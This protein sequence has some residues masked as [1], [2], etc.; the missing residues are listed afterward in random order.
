MTR[1][2][3]TRSTAAYSVIVKPVS[4]R[5]NLA[6][7]YCYYRRVAGMYPDAPAAAM[8]DEVLEALTVQVLRDS[9]PQAVF[10]WQGG[11]PLLAGR[12]FYD[13][14]FRLQRRYA[15]PGQIVRN[16]IQT[17][18]TLIDE[19]WCR[20]FR[21]RQVLVGLS[22]DGPAE[23]HD[24]N[25]RGVGGQPTHAAVMRGMGLL[26]KHEVAFNALSVVS[27]ATVGHGRRV[28][29]FLAER[30]LTWMQFIPCV[31]RDETGALTPHSVDG[32]SYGRFLCEAFDEWYPAWVGTVSVRTFE[33]VAQRAT[34]GPPELCV[35]SP[36]CG[37][38]VVVERNGDVYACDH[39]VYGDFRLGNLLEA[40]LRQ[41]VR[42]EPC[43]RLA[44]AKMA[45]PE[46]CATCPYEGLCYGGCPKE[47]FDAAAGTFG[48]PVLCEGYR[49]LFEHAFEPIRDIGW[50][51]V[52]GESPLAVGTDLRKQAAA[53]R[54][55]GR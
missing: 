55:K 18:G 36:T 1:S 42:R 32:P 47:R 54:R 39:F 38:A 51:I 29:R 4:A 40:P 19:E 11:E 28:F 21:E 7:D 33:N 43:Q 41:L 48:E 37:N 35:F 26:Q 46:R 25:R 9:G 27:A 52:R 31:E 14:A 50:R 17:N 45:A 16:T 30:G 12:E 2:Y 49:M 5:C 10:A 6:C 22:L 44:A 13:R 3:D 23:L 20:L 15:A 34:G 24:A 53:P 8:P